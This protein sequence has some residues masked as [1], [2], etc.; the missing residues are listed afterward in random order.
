MATNGSARAFYL[1]VMY[2]EGR[3]VPQDDKETVRILKGCKEATNG[4]TPSMKWKK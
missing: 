1:G 4:K 3:G 2:G